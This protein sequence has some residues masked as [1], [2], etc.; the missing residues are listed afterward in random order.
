MQTRRLYP[1]TL[2][3][4]SLLLPTS[5]RAA[6]PS[7]AAIVRSA[8]NQMVF[9]SEGAQMKINMTLRNRRGETRARS[10]F[11]KSRRVGGLARTLVRFLSPSDVAGTSFLFVEHKGK[12]DDQHMYLPALKA[13]K[14]IAGRQKNAR[15]MGSDF[16]YAD[17]EWRDLD[18]AAY[19]RLPDEQLTKQDCYVIEAIPAN[20]SAY[21]KTVSWIRKKDFVLLRIRFFDRRAR[22]HKVMFVK[23]VQRVGGALM[24]TRIKMSDKIKQHSTFLE[25]KDIRLRKDLSSDDF[26]VRALKQ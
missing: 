26:T 23:A 14:R 7:P 10:L 13:V 25:I 18:E 5:A 2:L 20:K 8:M 9:R 21:S 4:L 12:P 19:K 17:L 16:S 24:A 3:A 15:F 6:D 22:L 11:T 1:L